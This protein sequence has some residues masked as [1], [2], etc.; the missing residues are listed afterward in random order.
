MTL[1]EEYAQQQ[2]GEKS[3]SKGMSLADEYIA[4]QQVLPEVDMSTK[5]APIPTEGTV[6]EKD[7]GVGSLLRE[8][9]TMYK[10]GVEP[11]MLQLQQVGNAIGGTV[12]QVYNAVT[13][14][15]VSIY[16]DQRQRLQQKEKQLDIEL[17]P[18]GKALMKPSTTGQIAL[19]V[20]AGGITSPARVVGTEFGLGYGEKYSDTG[21]ITPSVKAGIT[22]AGIASPF[23][24]ASPVI[25]D[26]YNST[27][28]VVT[29]V[30]GGKATSK[31]AYSFIVKQSGET[32]KAIRDFNEAYAKSI[33]KKTSELS[34]DDKIM[35]LLNNSEVGSKMKLQAEYYNEFALGK[36]NKLEE[37][38]SEMVSRK[39]E[40]GD[41][42]LPIVQFKEYLKDSGE[43]YGELEKVLLDNFND[44]VKIGESSV[45]SLKETLLRSSTKAD[46][47]V[48][49]KRILGDL[50]VAS[51]D[52]LPVDRLLAMKH[53]L[54]SLN[55]KSTKAFKAGQVGSFIDSQI[56]KGVG[57]EAYQLWKEMN[58][59]Y[60]AKMIA[61]GDN[62]LG[63]LFMKSGLSGGKKGYSSAGQI[64]KAITSMNESGYKAFNE[65][66]Q[67]IGED[68]MVSVEKG[69]IKELM[70]RKKNMAEVMKQLDNYEFS[71][72]EGRGI[73]QGIDELKGLIPNTEATNLLNKSVAKKTDSTGWSDNIL[74]RF[75]YRIVGKAYNQVMKRLPSGETERVFTKIGDIM[76]DPVQF[77]KIKTLHGKALQEAFEAE[78]KTFKDKLKSLRDRSDLSQA[79]KIAEKNRLKIEEAEMLRV[80]KELEMGKTYG[81]TGST[82]PTY[83]KQGNEVGGLERL[84]GTKVQPTKEVIKPK[85]A[86][87]KLGIGLKQDTQ[88]GGL[89]DMPDVTKMPIENNYKQVD[90]LLGLTS[91]YGGKATG[92]NGVSTSAS[93]AYLKRFMDDIAN[94]KVSVDT[95]KVSELF[96]MLKAE[97][98]TMYGA[99]IAKEKAWNKAMDIVNSVKSNKNVSPKVR[100]Q[101]I[102]AVKEYFD[103][104]D[105]TI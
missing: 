71:T 77:K 61:Q 58:K 100:E 55:L 92:T 10:T 3:V 95:A 15:D 73:Q 33:N 14:S 74:S 80:K 9:Q 90:G 30:V 45:S 46:D 35:A 60:S 20:T 88:V 68:A 6:P 57:E 103:L 2:M 87:E 89:N 96:D 4:Q 63:K 69:I 18:Q 101:M 26:A 76:K 53:D 97:G 13:N 28:N 91:K 39:I 27:K 65:M 7:R 21:E 84:S 62:P 86:L 59:R 31:D 83:P 38:I 47:S 43:L 51:K 48:V 99:T 102:K 98:T 81:V 44:T 54:N 82:K 29:K 64:A 22:Q 17:D 16:E 75:K 105:S 24:G 36:Q 104:L 11:T 94:P 49:I 42:E 41:I 78:Q 34:D 85:S 1:A 72:V 40:D 8:L 93:K 79:E 50:E 23:S 70:S 12:E 67:V 52:G 19:G 5:Q 32:D 56:K 37:Q 25:E 66:R